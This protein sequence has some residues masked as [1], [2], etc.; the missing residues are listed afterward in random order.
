VKRYYRKPGKPHHARQPTTR[1]GR[2]LERLTAAYEREA[3]SKARLATFRA[4]LA[5]Q[6][7][8]LSQPIKQPCYNDRGEIVAY[9]TI[10]KV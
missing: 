9:A 3:D 7:Y 5:E 2:L 8:N 6:L 4:N 10:E 1:G